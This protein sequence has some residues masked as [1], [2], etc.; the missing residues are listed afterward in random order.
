MDLSFFKERFL[1]Y[2]FVRIRKDSLD[3]WKQAESFENQSTKRIHESNLQGSD[4]RIRICESL[5]PDLS[6]TKQNKPFWSQD[7]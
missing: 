4:S 2:G 5:K 6:I 3:S 7:S 1:Y